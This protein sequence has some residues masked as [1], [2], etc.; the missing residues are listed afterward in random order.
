MGIQEQ[1][2]HIRDCIYRAKQQD[3]A[4]A[5]RELAFEWDTCW[6][7]GDDGQVTRHLIEQSCGIDD[8]ARSKL[9]RLRFWTQCGGTSNAG[10]AD[11]LSARAAW[12]A[13]RV[14]S[15]PT[16]RLAWALYEVRSLTSVC[17]LEL[18]KLAVEHLLQGG[19]PQVV[20]ALASG[21]PD[22]SEVLDQLVRAATHPTPEDL[23]L[24]HQ[25]S[26]AHMMRL[27]TRGEEPA[28]RWRFMFY[29]VDKLASQ[30]LTDLDL[31]VSPRPQLLE[32]VL[33]RSPQA[34]FREPAEW[35]LTGTQGP[36]LTVHA[37]PRTPVGDPYVVTFVGD[38][39]L[40]PEDLQHLRIADAAL[41]GWL[42]E[43]LHAT[44]DA[45]AVQVATQMCS[46]TIERK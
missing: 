29:A 26:E 42:S 2:T 44:Q 16:Q 3:D 21:F 1:L 37:L 46:N 6:H 32:S 25:V 10:I 15:G 30:R 14:V 33:T 40:S 11:K 22:L 8:D 9:L 4:E 45:R 24:L 17:M 18:G 7:K 12:L 20:R 35:V 43:K 19:S 31:E 23:M 36:I 27:Y 39:D 38:E 34:S 28:P 5:W 41:F 13:A